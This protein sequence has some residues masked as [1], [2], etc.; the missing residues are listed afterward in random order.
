MTAD[1]KIHQ[2]TSQPLTL[3]IYG[4][5]VALST[6]INHRKLPPHYNL[7]V[8]IAAIFLPTRTWNFNFQLIPVHW[9]CLFVRAHPMIA[10]Y[11]LWTLLVFFS[12]LT[13]SSARWR[14]VIKRLGGANQIHS[15]RCERQIWTFNP[16]ELLYRFRSS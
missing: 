7:S 8:R 2:A 12:P 10:A 14:P 6:N 15:G 1:I 9:A 13:S 16:S 11:L 5:R 3:N 4:I